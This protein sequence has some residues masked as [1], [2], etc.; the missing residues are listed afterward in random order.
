V[1]NFA[2]PDMIGHTGNLKA[3]I[4]TCETMDKY[5]NE[6]VRAYLSKNGTVI[7]TADHGNIEEML[8]L[9]TGEANTE[10][11][12]NPVPFVIINK[13][14]K[15]KIKLRSGGKLGD[16]APT[17]LDLLGIKKAGEMGGRTLII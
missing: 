5:V 9:K 7:I 2:A 16:I 6:I 4:Q 17:I 11:S 1:L 14:L 12:T 3:A 15:N 13:Y 8:N 10:H